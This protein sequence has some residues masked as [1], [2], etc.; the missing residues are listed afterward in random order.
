VREGGREGEERE[1]STELQS[2][3]NVIITKTLTSKTVRH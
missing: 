1:D 2:K 3:I